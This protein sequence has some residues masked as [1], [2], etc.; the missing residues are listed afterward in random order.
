M[1]GDNMRPY[2]FTHANVLNGTK[3]MSLQKDMT[4]LVN[5]GLI[6]SIV[7]GSRAVPA[8]YKTIDLKGS[9]LMP[10]LINLHAHLPGSGKA[11]TIDASTG[12]LIR[13]QLTSPIGRRIMTSMCYQNAL[14]GLKSGVTTIRTVGGLGDLDAEIRDSIDEGKKLGPRIL[15]SNTAIS[16]PD[17]HMAGTLAYIANSTEEAVSYVQQ[18]AAGRPDLIKLMVTGG[19]L[20]ADDEGT[21]GAMRMPPEMVKAV[22]GEAHRLGY[23][24][25]AHVLNAEGMRVCASCGV[26]TI[27][28]GA[29]LTE[30]EKELMKAHGTAVICTI[31]PLVPMKLGDRAETGLSDL[32]CKNGSWDFDGVVSCAK[33]CLAYD[34]P[35]GLG[36]DTGCPFV[37]HYDF[38]RELVYFQR[39]VGVSS[40]FALHTATLG[41]AEI[42]GISDITG[43]IT[44]G[45]SA[46]FL[47]TKENPLEDLNNLSQPAMV[48]IRGNVIN[49]PRIKHNRAYDRILNGIHL[50]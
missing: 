7:E 34:I 28:H 43:S 30:Q 24:V 21:P 20:D 17:G 47:I 3:D 8:G 23:P 35:V 45:K 2:A 37:M 5:D 39:Y 36:N 33:D 12:E 40:A 6:Q 1:E 27:E 25:A 22:C 13:K 31:S 10:G 32:M 11:H 38:W 18:I 44:E 15:T 50:D 42:A 46:D 4:L 29:V 16:V 19:I 9:Y 41:N 26:D 48:V 14:A 49:R